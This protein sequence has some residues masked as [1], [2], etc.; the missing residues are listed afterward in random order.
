MQISSQT[1][2]Y[3]P[4]MEP[5]DIDDRVDTTMLGDIV[6]SVTF[7]DQ[8]INVGDL[9][10]IEDDLNTTDR[11]SNIVNRVYVA[12]I[13]G[14]HHPTD[15]DS[16][17]IFLA[18]LLVRIPLNTT[19]NRVLV[20]EVEVDGEDSTIDPNTG[21]DEYLDTFHDSEYD[22]FLQIEHEQDHDDEESYVEHLA[23]E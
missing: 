12:R 7:D 15:G 2:E 20:S 16:P 1:I 11:E 13:T 5:G 4:C 22:N 19:D 10:V 21:L 8:T 17:E 9:A 18:G 23:G 3:G 6:S 14:I